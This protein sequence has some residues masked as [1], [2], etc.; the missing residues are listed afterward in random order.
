MKAGTNL[1]KVLRKGLFAVTGELA[2]PRG[3][4]VAALR[5]K[6]DL[7]R[8]VVDAIH[9]PDNPGCRGSSV[10]PGRLDCFFSKWGLN[11]SW[12][13]LPGTETALLFRAISSAQRPSASATSFV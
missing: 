6:A 13:W 10:K 7:L 8:G 1:E 5:R 9:V 12:R 3:N 2:P 4:D 11:R